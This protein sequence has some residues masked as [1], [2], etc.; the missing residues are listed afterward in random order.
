M[1]LGGKYVEELR[2]AG[3]QVIVADPPAPQ[4]NQSHAKTSSFRIY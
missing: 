4:P 2:D 1:K 3:L